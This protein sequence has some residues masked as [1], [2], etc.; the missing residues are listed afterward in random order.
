MT[1]FRSDHP[2]QSWARPRVWGGELRR[3]AAGTA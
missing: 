1:V 3:A 2:R